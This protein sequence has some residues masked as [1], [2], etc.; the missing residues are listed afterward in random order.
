MVTLQEQFEKDF[1][2]KEAKEIRA[3]FKYKGSIFTS[4]DLDLREY[5]GL[6]HL[7]L[8]YNNLNLTSLN[9]SENKN[10]TFL[11]LN[12]N[13]LTSLDFLNILPNPEKLKTLSVFNNNIRPTDI[14][15]FSR[16][17]NL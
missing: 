2:N 11:D 16:F 14:S 15:I 4:Y 12:E 6:T 17:V 13:N 7:G 8:D 10:L 9:L 3:C 5:K 1:P